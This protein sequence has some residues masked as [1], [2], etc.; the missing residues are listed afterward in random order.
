[1][2]LFGLVGEENKFV[3]I[4]LIASFKRMK[5]F[6]NYDAIVK[7]LEESS[8]LEL[9]EAKDAVRR[10]VPLPKPGTE[11]FKVTY[12]VAIDRSVYAVSHFPSNDFCTHNRMLTLS[13][14]RIR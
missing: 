11:E 2:F 7:S 4:K 14:E 10:K 3:P 1:K 13:A 5:R 9:N 6:P 12:G 8:T